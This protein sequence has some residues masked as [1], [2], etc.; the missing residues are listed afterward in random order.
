MNKLTR[1][2]RDYKI[3]GWFW[4][5]MLA[6]LIRGAIWKIYIWLHFMLVRLDRPY[7]VWAVCI[8]YFTLWIW[9][10]LLLIGNGKRYPGMVK[11]ALLGGGLLAVAAFLHNAGAITALLRDDFG[12]A[13]WVTFLGTCGLVFRVALASLENRNKKTEAVDEGRVAQV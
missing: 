2:L 8:S 12:V 4:A 6:I 9:L 13:A 11:D 1:I 3:P 7:I 5:L 10:F